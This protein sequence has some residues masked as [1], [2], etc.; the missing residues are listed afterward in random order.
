MTNRESLEKELCKLKEGHLEQIVKSTIGE[1]LD[2]ISSLTKT[3][4]LIVTDL[5]NYLEKE[6]L[7]QIRFLKNLKDVGY[8][9][10]LKG[11]ANNYLSEVLGEEVPVLDPY[12]D[13]IIRGEPFADRQTFREKLKVLFDL[14]DK[15]TLAAIG[16]RYSGRSHARILVQHVGDQVGKTYIYVD[17][18]TSTVGEVIDQLINEMGLVIDKRDPL[19]QDSTKTKDFLQ[20]LRAISRDEFVP[21]NKRWCIVFDHHDVPE[22]APSAKEFAELMIKDQLE[23]TLRNVWVVMLGL[24]TCTRISPMDI[25]NKI[26]IADLLRL[27]PSDIEAYLNELYVKKNQQPMDPVALQIEKQKVLDGLVIPLST[28]DSLLAVYTRLYNYI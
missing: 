20:R 6:P 12:S 26:V 28:K 15:R 10:E 8:T 23:K 22:T 13:L 19:A 24:G 3:V 2:H 21:A 11:S 25:Q 1:R 7:T 17:L 14:P 9:S 16:P 27:E 5:L 4:P 18:L